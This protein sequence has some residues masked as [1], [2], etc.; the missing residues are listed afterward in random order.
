MMF[1]CATTG[2]FTVGTHPDHYETVGQGKQ[3]VKGLHA[4]FTNGMFDSEK[5]QE[6]LHWTDEQ[7]MVVEEW[8]L[9]HRDF[10]NG[11]QLYDPEKVTVQV[12]QGICMFM[13]P[14]DD[15]GVRSTVQCG[16]PVEDGE[17]FCAKHLALFEVTEDFELDPVG[18]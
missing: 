3:M 1:T 12:T 13:Q 10:G 8:L 4:L 11:L 5:E 7:R 9:K 15:Q 2:R 17:D 16:S 14:V 18:T 6:R